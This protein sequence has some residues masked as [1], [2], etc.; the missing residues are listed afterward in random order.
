MTSGC[1]AGYK[2]PW[3]G[4]RASSSI[5]TASIRAKHPATAR[6]TRNHPESPGI[7]TQSYRDHERRKSWFNKEL[8]SGLHRAAPQRLTVV[9]AFGF[10]KHL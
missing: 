1:S 9:G 4:G 10:C 6:T 5:L 2:R 8:Q 7:G 3:S